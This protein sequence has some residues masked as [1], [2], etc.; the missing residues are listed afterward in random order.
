MLCSGGRSADT[1]YWRAATSLGRGAGG[2]AVH[3]AHEALKRILRSCGGWLESRPELPPNIFHKPCRGR[4]A[5]ETGTLIRLTAAQRLPLVAAQRRLRCCKLR[6]PHDAPSR[7]RDDCL[8]CRGAG[9]RSMQRLVSVLVPGA[10]VVGMVSFTIPS[11]I[12]ARS[13][14]GHSCVLWPN[15][16]RCFLPGRMPNSPQA[17]H[18]FLYVDLLPEL[19]LDIFNELGVEHCTT[20]T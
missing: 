18:S 5:A 16:F 12:L 3:S 20:E 13:V 10:P 8:F 17:L 4:C 1:A 7:T 2:S 9:A 6:S 15:R 11:E 14:E 19:S